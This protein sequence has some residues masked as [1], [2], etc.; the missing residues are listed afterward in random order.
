YHVSDGTTTTSNIVT[1]TINVQNVNDNP[2]A[3]LDGLNGAFATTEDTPGLIID[4]PGVLANDTDADNLTPPLFAGLT[5]SVVIGSGP[6]HAAP[7]G[8]SFGTSGLGAGGFTYKP[9]PDFFGND[10]FAYV[11]RDGSGGISNTVTVTLTVA[12]QPD[13]PVA[14]G[15]RFSLV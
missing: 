11:V 8:F 9:A 12:N 15:N 6:L 2:V 3:N 4:A 7:G 10:S 5:P 1:V 13:P 14:V